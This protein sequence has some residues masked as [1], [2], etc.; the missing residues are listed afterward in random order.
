MKFPYRILAV[1]FLVSNFGMAQNMADYNGAWEGT[2]SNPK[3][4]QIEVSIHD[5]GTKEATLELSNETLR[6]NFPIVSENDSEFTIPISETQ[7]FHGTCSEDKE[8]ISGFLK[9]GLLLYHIMLKRTTNTSYSGI[10]NLLMVEELRSDKV[11]LS[12]EN[13][14]QETYQAYPFF[15]DDRFTGTWA[16]DFQ[17]QQDTLSFSDFKTGV[18][19][20]GV[21]RETEITLELFVDDYVIAT[22]TL[23]RTEAEW[24]RGGFTSEKRSSK[25]KFPELE[26]LVV[27]DS[28][29]NTHAILVQQQGV[30]VYE[31][32]FDGY[33][34]NLPHDMR[35][36]SKSISSTLMGIAKDEGLYES[37]D[38]SIF[39]FLPK[40]YQSYKNSE[41]AGIDLKSL[42]TMSS[43]LD[44]V[45][46]G[47]NANRAS[48]AT[49]EN[50][51]QSADWTAS[52]LQAEMLYP[53]NTHANYGSANPYLLGVA[54]DSMV[55]HS[56]ALYIDKTLFQ[57]L[58]ITNYIVQTDLNGRPYFGG[59][60]YLTPP[61]MLKYGTL[62]LNKGSWKGKRIVSEAWIEKSV[63][64]YRALEN[65]TKQNVYGYLWWHDI[66]K[67]GN[68]TIN[69]LEARGAGGQYIVVIPELDAVVVI[70]S[71]NFRNGRG[72]Q[73][74]KILANFLLPKLVD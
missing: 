15:G 17:K 49:E 27:N 24:K 55:P 51:Q 59:G 73:P 44:A 63:T 58:G 43:G 34:E 1:L 33:H 19:F 21:L 52:V 41:N 37:V 64:P 66:Y 30:L 13:G 74:E 16:Y 2:L 40:E 4:F 67:V 14:D 72:Q 54:L 9:S 8:T 65:T 56:M 28:F 20:R 42:L 5:F 57:P 23:S 3:S 60:M 39:E 45:D 35:S 53:P 11:Y 26:A 61:D 7:S 69:T 68:Q 10:W 38:Q 31:Q 46:F 36:A 32:Y 25:L 29:P 18:T 12:I 48:P 22:A 70:T 62:Y 50:Y 47:E 71:G 6:A